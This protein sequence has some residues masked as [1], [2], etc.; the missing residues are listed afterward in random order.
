MVLLKC[1]LHKASDLVYFVHLYTNSPPDN[2]EYKMVFLVHVSQGNRGA[3][4]RNDVKEIAFDPISIAFNT[5][6]K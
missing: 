4:T 2:P 6:R 3:D 5:L 1:K